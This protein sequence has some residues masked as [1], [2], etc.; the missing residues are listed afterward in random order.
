MESNM[1][2]WQL[3]FLTMA[4]SELVADTVSTKNES[5]A[6]IFSYNKKPTVPMNPK[7]AQRSLYKKES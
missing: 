5:K 3:G 7:K 6:S 2:L 1:A 4:F